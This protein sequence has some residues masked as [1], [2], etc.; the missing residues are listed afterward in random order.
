MQASHL[1]D[2]IY[3][4]KLWRTLKLQIGLHYAYGDNS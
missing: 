1:Q 2:T 4:D 3:G